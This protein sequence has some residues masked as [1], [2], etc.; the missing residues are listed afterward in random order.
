[1]CGAYSVDSYVGFWVNYPIMIHCKDIF[2][3]VI[4]S[5]EGPFLTYGE[6]SLVSSLKICLGQQKSQH[7]Q[8]AWET[9][10]FFSRCARYSEVNIEH[11]FRERSKN[12]KKPHLRRAQKRLKQTKK[13]ENAPVW[14]LTVNRTVGSVLWCTL[15]GL[16]L[17]SQQC[18][19]STALRLCCELVWGKGRGPINRP[20]WCRH[21]PLPNP[22]FVSAQT[23]QPSRSL[24]WI[25]SS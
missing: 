12:Q 17:P 9:W 25:H 5:Y 18:C 22:P 6:T 8:P 4:L 24:F 23:A 7:L 2:R 15:C 16:R 1:M 20:F 21:N 19:G 3:A 11:S 13:W 14:H 10:E